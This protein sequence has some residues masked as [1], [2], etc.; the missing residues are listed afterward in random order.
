[1][2]IVKMQ[3]FAVNV[4]DPWRFAP[5]ATQVQIHLNTQQMQTTQCVQQNHSCLRVK[6]YFV[7]INIYVDTH[8][9]R[10]VYVHLCN[11]SFLQNTNSKMHTNKH[12]CI[13]MSHH[14]ASRVVCSR[15]PFT[16]CSRKLKQTLNRRQP[17]IS[18]WLLLFWFYLFFTHVLMSHAKHIQY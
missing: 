18:L 14:S 8:I 13:C 5:T 11:V 15:A 3:L 1:M 2:Q 16:S 7:H 4:A 17:L 12:P 6:M 9:H 10:Y